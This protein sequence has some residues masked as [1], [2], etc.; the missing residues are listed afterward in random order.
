M[1]SGERFGMYLVW[2]VIFF[3]GFEVGAEPKYALYLLEAGVVALLLYKA[4]EWAARR[5]YSD[6][7]ESQSLPAQPT[8]AMK[9]AV[10]LQLVESGQIPPEKRLPPD[11]VDEYFGVQI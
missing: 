1:S 11:Q 9:K 7:N 3:L 5:R 6:K 2:A 10:Y 4:Y 8:P